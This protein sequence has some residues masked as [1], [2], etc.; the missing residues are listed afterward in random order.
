[1]KD[2]SYSLFICATFALM[3]LISGNG[4]SIAQ[5][6]VPPLSIPGTGAYVLGELIYPLDNRPTPQCHA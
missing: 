1:M 3:G 4:M 5:V 2:V 6:T